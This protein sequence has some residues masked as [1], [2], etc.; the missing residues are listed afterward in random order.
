[1]R[2]RSSHMGFD[3]GDFSPECLDAGDELLDRHGV[4]VLLSDFDQ[5]VAGLAGEKFV[6]VHGLNR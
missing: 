6:Q 5:R 4:E 2:L 3:A 1:M